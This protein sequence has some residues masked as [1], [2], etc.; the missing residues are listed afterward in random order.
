[1]EKNNGKPERSAKGAGRG[2]LQMRRGVAGESPHQQPIQLSRE[3][4]GGA[5]AAPGP[6]L[7]SPALSSGTRSA[8]AIPARLLLLP[9]TDMALSA[10]AAAVKVRLAGPGAGVLPSWVTVPVNR[11]PPPR[12]GGSGA[13]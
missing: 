12:R 9:R 10:A 8:P 6:S 7:L 5:R 13:R 11:A 4:R 2:N 1:M 3:G